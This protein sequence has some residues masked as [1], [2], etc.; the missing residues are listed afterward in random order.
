MKTMELLFEGS[1]TLPTVVV[2][3]GK[4]SIIGRAIGIDQKDW[5]DNLVKNLN[6]FSVDLHDINEIHIQLEYMNSETNRALMQMLSLVDKKYNEGKSIRVIWHCK[7]YD[8]VMLDHISIFK[9]I[10]DTPI[11]IALESA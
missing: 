7:V 5:I 3:D 9:S 6:V 8:T 4:L 11:E 1:K 2:K 10:I